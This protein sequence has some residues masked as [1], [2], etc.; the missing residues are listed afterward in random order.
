MDA[1]PHAPWINNYGVWVDEFEYMGLG[2]CLEVIWP[3][4]KVWLDSDTHGEKFLDR[5]G[6]WLSL[7]GHC[8]LVGSGVGELY[9]S[10][11]V[12]SRRADHVYKCVHF[13]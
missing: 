4:A 5:C 11:V 12:Y 9:E 1:K 13:V 7:L 10:D 6:Q 3:K 2:D 8:Q